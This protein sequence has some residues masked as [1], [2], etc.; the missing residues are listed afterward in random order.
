MAELVAKVVIMGGTVHHPGN[1]GPYAEANIAHDP[2]AAHLVLGA[3]WPVTLVGLDV[4]MAAWIGPEELGRIQS[5]DTATA[6]FVWDI[7]Q[8]YLGFYA[9]RHERPGCPLHDP[10]AALVALDPSLA[11]WFESPV[12]VE[13]RSQ[14]NR[15]M[16]I[17][18][19]REFAAAER[20]AGL[21]MVK[22]VTRLD[23]DRLIP[24]FLD[25]LLAG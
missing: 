11:E 15:G 23:N 17:V 5:T 9:S 22:I 4:T 7:L 6:R 16:L 2:E 20:A 24:A 19:R 21:P 18:D 14:D 13:L 10:S 3:A 8:H 1:I 25:G 12:G